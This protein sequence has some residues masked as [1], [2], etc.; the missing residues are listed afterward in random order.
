MSFSPRSP[1]SYARSESILLWDLTR[2][3]S[4]RVGG[5]IPLYRG[6]HCI[7]C[8]LVR[9]ACSGPGARKEVWSRFSTWSRRASPCHG[10]DL[11]CAGV[12]RLAAGVLEFLLEVLRPSLAASV[13][14]M[15]FRTLLPRNVQRRAVLWRRSPVG[16]GKG[17]FT[18]FSGEGVGASV[19]C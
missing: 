18:G 7:S 12:S 1:N 9:L 11:R 5:C 19:H 6:M 4:A 16:A 10:R 17:W 2:R 13:R 14:S 15:F 3:M 8:R